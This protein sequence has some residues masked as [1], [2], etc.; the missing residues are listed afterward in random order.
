MINIHAASNRTPPQ[1]RIGISGWTYQP[2]RGTFY[3]KSLAH[4]REL[5]FASR[6][7]NSIEINGTFYSLQRPECRQ[8]IAGVL[9]PR[10]YI[11]PGNEI[12]TKLQQELN[13]FH[14]HSTSR[15]P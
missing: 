5:A 13:L 12:R 7:L 1:T 14:S 11:I 15:N 6:Q 9:D 8:I 2:W 4:K 3:P 10:D